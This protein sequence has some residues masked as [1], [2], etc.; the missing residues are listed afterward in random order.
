MKVLQARLATKVPPALPWDQRVGLAVIL[1]KAKQEPLAR[2]QVTLCL[3]EADERKLRMLSPGALYR[4]MVLS[5]AFDLSLEPHL[6]EL[7]LNLVPVELR[8][9]LRSLA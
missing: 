9:R 4:L 1:A 8:E 5:R 6:R 7:A 2:K 3:A